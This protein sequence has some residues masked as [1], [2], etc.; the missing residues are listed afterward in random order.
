[1]S[2][3][4]GNSRVFYIDSYNRI[5][6]NDTNFQIKVDV[7]QGNTY[8][9][10]ALM[11]LSCP[12]SFYNFSSGNNTFVLQELSVNYSITI[13]AGNYQKNN[14]ITTLSSLLTTASALA[15]NNWIYTVSYPN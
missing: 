10:V 7:P 5:S 15:G 4:H 3:Y 6:G 11:Q 13:P 14:I 2:I 9:K 12:K 8:N 1:M